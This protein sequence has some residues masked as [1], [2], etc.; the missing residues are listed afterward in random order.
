MLPYF[1]YTEDVQNFCQF[2]EFIIKGSVS[3]NTYVCT[4]TLKCH[5]TPRITSYK[6]DPSTSPLIPTDKVL[7]YLTLILN[8]YSCEE[9]VNEIGVVGYSSSYHYTR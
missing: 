3:L 5:P 1:K 7:Q 8:G 6:L 4:Y 9:A 2:M